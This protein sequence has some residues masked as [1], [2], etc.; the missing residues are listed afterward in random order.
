MPLASNF[1]LMQE[2]NNCTD[3]DLMALYV[4]LIDDCE[5]IVAEYLEALVL[6]FWGKYGLLANWLQLDNPFII[7]WYCRVHKNIA[8]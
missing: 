4:P 3:N 5:S 7:S 6:K 1:V 2:I 8:S